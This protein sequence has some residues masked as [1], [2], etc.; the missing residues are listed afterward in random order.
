MASSSRA[1]I[2][3]AL[4]D[5]IN[6]SVELRATIEAA[7][8]QLA[9]MV[10]ANMP[11]DTGEA[12]QSVEVKARRTKYKKLTTR[13]IKVGSVYS[14]DDPAK[15]NTIEYGRSAEDDNSS[16]PEFAPFR[17]A[18]AEFDGKDFTPTKGTKRAPNSNAEW[19]AALGF[20]D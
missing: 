8:E 9:L 20:E 10:E 15:I 1:E 11:V 12:K 3:R 18:A 19:D 2:Q 17:K 6:E 4:L 13:R 7:P 5:A 14:D 16:T